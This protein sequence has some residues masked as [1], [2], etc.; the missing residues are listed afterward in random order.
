M[1]FFEQISYSLEIGHELHVCD[2]TNDRYRSVLFSWFSSKFHSILS[3]DEKWRKFRR[4][5]NENCSIKCAKNKMQNQNLQSYFS[6][7]TN[8]LATSKSKNPLKI[9]I[10]IELLSRRK[11]RKEPNLTH[12]VFSIKI[13]DHETRHFWK[14]KLRLNFK[15]DLAQ[16]LLQ[17]ELS[18]FTKIKQNFLRKSICFGILGL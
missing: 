16:N 1:I 2:L 5:L 15:I 3:K 13:D 11:Y 10:P 4:K 6:Q 18:K 12:W 7:K 14:K 17:N 9:W 8:Q